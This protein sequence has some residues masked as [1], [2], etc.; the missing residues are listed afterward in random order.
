M[1]SREMTAPV[2]LV[3]DDPRNLVA[4]EALLDGLDLDIVTARSG[5]EC[6]REVLQR[7]FAVVLLDVQMPEMDGIET[8]TMIRSR[9]TSR[10]VPI[11]FLTSHSHTDEIVSRAYEVGAVDFLFKPLQPAPLRSKVS[12]FVELYRRGQEIEAAEKREHERSLS[13]L[14]ASIEAAALRSQMEAERDASERV[15]SLADR[16]QEQTEALADAHARKDE[17]LAMLGHELRNP[18]ASLR[19]ALEIARQPGASLDV[20]S[21][22]DRQVRQLQR[23]VDDLLDVARISRGTIELRRAPASLATIVDQAVEQCQPVIAEKGHALDLEVDDVEIVAD[24]ARL[25]QVV[26]NLL[27]NAARYTDPQGRLRVSAHREGDAAV[28]RVEDNGRG[29]SHEQLR[30]VF[31][32]FVQV[33]RSSDAAQGFGLGLSLVRRMVEKHGGTVSVHSDGEG[34]GSAFTVRLPI[35][36]RSSATMP[37]VGA[38]STSVGLDLVVVEDNDD[39]RELMESYLRFRGHRV[40]VADNG[41]SGLER[42]CASPPTIAFVDIGL[43][44]IDGYEVARQFRARHPGRKTTL[45]AV[46]GFGQPEDRARALQ[47]GFDEHL[48]KPVQ[49]AVI[50]RVLRGH[51]AA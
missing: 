28:I 13:E 16:L 6:L 14:R 15:Q 44:G 22:F 47:A 43:P 37:A 46:T 36:A 32:A 27:H 29:I 9:P 10:H 18:L 45:V 49:P 51:S 3:D 38:E 41:L 50:E 2:L 35:V 25:T 48:V 31:D 24:A 30:R 5:F 4:L 20:L 34:C 17:F 42:L 19:Y 23:L 21:V 40:A 11:I 7:E 12:V 1:L 26:A 8:A 33:D 39:A